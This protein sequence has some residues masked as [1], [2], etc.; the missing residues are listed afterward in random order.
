MEV[1]L[2]TNAEP[3]TAEALEPRGNTTAPLPAPNAYRWLEAKTGSVRI[4]AEETPHRG[5][6]FE[7]GSSLTQG[8]KTIENLRPFI[9]IDHAHHYQSSQM[10]SPISEPWSELNPITN[11]QAGKSNKI[12]R[13]LNY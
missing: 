4:N 8:F 9:T 12:F 1:D 3:L 13:T 5:W 6:L 11:T 7:T 2:L 10:I